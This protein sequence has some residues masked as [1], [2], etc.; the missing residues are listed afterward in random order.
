MRLLTR[1]TF[2]SITVFSLLLCVTSLILWPLSFSRRCRFWLFDH[3]PLH[4]QT[5]NAVWTLGFRYGRLAIHHIHTEHSDYLF[6]GK[7]NWNWSSIFN[8]GY[9]GAR[10]KPWSVTQISL[11]FI[12]VVTGIPL[13][14]RIAI[15]LRTR[16]RNKTP[17]RPDTH[18]RHDP[19]RA[20]GR[21]A[22]I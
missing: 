10:H 12:A 1:Y 21:E 5:S 11:W 15:Q 19:I 3:S 18:C 22:D 8:Y 20:R 9:Y 4:F 7:Y 17:I 6:G 14:I 13:F 16:M 2:N